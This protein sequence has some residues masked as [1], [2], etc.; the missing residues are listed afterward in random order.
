MSLFSPPLTGDPEVPLNL[1]PDRDVG[2]L[3]RRIVAVLIDSIVVGI[4]GTLIALPFFD[5]FS[6]LGALGR[7][8]GFCLAVPISCLPASNNLRSTIWQHCSKHVHVRYWRSTPG[9]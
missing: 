3:W 5:F 2:S 8:V 6:R 7:L 9:A 4:A 1:P